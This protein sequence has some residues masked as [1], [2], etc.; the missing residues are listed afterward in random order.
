MKKQFSK[1]F[2]PAVYLVISFFVVA[3]PRLVAQEH[4]PAQNSWPIVPILLQY[5]HVPQYFMEWMDDNP[6][7]SMI[8]GAVWPGESPRYQ[9]VLTEKKSGKRVYYC[10]SP[11]MVKYLTAT[12]EHALLTNIDFRTA[13]STGQQPTYAFGFR[14]EKGQAVL[15]RFIPAT[16]PSERG[17]GLTPVDTS[18]PL[19]L[20]YRDAGTAAGEGSAVQIAGKLSEAAAWPEISAPPYFVA[21]RGTFVEGMEIGILTTG[22]QYW[23][24]AKS[25]ESLAEGAEWQLKNDEGI[26][27]KLRVT[28]IKGD[29]LTID[30]V[31][32]PDLGGGTLHLIARKTPQGLAL[33]SVSVVDG[34]HS[35]QISFKPELLAA[36]GSAG[37]PDVSFQIDQDGHRKLIEGRISTEVK[38]DA[39]HLVWKPESPS[40]AKKHVLDTKVSIE[41][42]GYKID[43]Q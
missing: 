42:D 43:V 28:S 15:W 16:D 11:G 19:R 1:A 35:M 8:E 14:D 36:P 30:E 41:P 38:A 34:K 6:Q 23:H 3:S 18:G 10:S 5:E 27:R 29:E 4:E 40:W 20:L 24:V 21:F 22:S 33:G 13:K 31:A 9:T 7:Y 17:A 32:N 37:Q 26:S 12:G 39:R 2:K 25:P